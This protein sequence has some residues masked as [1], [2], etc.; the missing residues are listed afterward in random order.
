MDRILKVI[1]KFLPSGSVGR[2][3]SIL[4]GGTALGQALAVLVTPLLTRIYRAEDFGYFQMYFAFIGFAALAVTLRYELAILLPEQEEIAANV[5]AA[6]FCA[7]L[8]MSILLGFTAWFVHRN[9]LLPSNATGLHAYLWIIPLAVC[10][11]GIFQ[12]L[13]F[14]ALRQKAYKRV[15]GTRLTQAFSQFGTQATIGMLHSG[16]LGLLLGDAVGRM[17]G[18]LSLARLLWLR[19]RNVFRSIR[20]RTI[21]SAA[22]RYRRFPLV[23]SWSSLLNIGAYSV[24]P[25]LMAGL[26]GPKMLGWFA[27]G[28]RVLG[29]PATLIGQAVSQVYAVEAATLAESDPRALYALFFRSAKRLALLGAVPFVVFFLFSPSLFA[30]VFGES[31]REAGVYARVLAAMHY[32]AFVSW[33]LTQTLNILEQQ[34]WQ[35]GWDVARLLL[36]C[37]SLWIAFRLG[38]SARVAI[39]ALAA[40]MFLGY[41]I[42]LLLSECAIRKR[43]RQIQRRAFDEVV[44]VEPEYSESGKP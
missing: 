28:D 43:I 12:T 38:S 32:L 8:L 25:L 24:P 18:S 6:T 15:A 4:A 14:W 16:P 23:S 31:W 26:Y 33:P 1:A 10:G 9:H 3:V 13:N 11:S 36:T 39:G 41:A 34:Y 22:N 2:S 17:S 42:H 7:V 5:V 21:W 19:S 35:L 40:A 37:G 27:L 29:A 20:W 44:T 30:L